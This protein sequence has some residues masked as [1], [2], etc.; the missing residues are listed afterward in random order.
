M[1]IPLV[2]PVLCLAPLSGCSAQVAS[3][4][5][6][7]GGVD[8]SVLDRI[9][10]D[11]VR[12]QRVDYLNIRKRDWRK[13]NDYLQTLARADLSKGTRD[14][15][16]ATLIN[17]YNATMIKLVVERLHVGYS[18][19]ERDFLVF[20]QSLVRTRKGTVSLNDLENEIIRKQFKEPRIHVALVCGAESCPPLLPRAYVAGDLDKTLEDNMRVFVNDKQRNCIDTKAH[21]LKLSKIFNWYAPD[22][23]GKARLSSYVKRYV[24][25]DLTGFQVSFVEYSWKLNFARPVTGK[26]IQTLAKQTPMYKDRQREIVERQVRKGSLFE[27]V[28]E[29]SGFIQVDDPLGGSPLWVQKL[30][31]GPL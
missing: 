9:L 25:E 20:K 14:E 7:S 10:K 4:R 8:H 21:K 16:L 5:P 26:W 12:D 1:K 27:V 23:G 13:L 15:R 28:L 19:S 17:L 24:K 31:V 11:N 2:L 29:D 3:P 18:P 22:F 30:A 6:R